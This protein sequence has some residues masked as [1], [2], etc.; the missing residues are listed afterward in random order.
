MNSDTSEWHEQQTGIRQGCPL[1]PYMLLV[2]MTTLFH[3]IHIGDPQNLGPDQFV[4]QFFMKL[5]MRTI[6]FA[7]PTL[8]KQ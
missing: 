2:I 5:F 7:C 1:S 8:E 6:R 3:D 4:E